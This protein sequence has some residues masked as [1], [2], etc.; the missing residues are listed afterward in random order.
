M[1]YRQDVKQSAVQQ[2]SYLNS[3]HTTYLAQTVPP[4]VF[5]LEKFHCK[6]VNHVALP[7]TWNYETFSAL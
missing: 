7:I 4:I 2:N 1:Q 5:V 3:N 6:F